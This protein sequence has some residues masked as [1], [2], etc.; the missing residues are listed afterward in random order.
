[1]LLNDH[2]RS[3]LHNRIGAIVAPPYL[4]DVG[5]G[6]KSVPKSIAF[7]KYPHGIGLLIPYF[8]DSVHSG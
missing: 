4:S 7:H 2:E 8:D 6:S 5:T 3:R 1:M